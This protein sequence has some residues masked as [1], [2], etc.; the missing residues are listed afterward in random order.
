M[1]SSLPALHVV[2]DD[3]VIRTLVC[4][5][6]ERAGFRSEGFSSPAGFL[7]A[8][9]LEPPDLIVLDLA[10]GDTGGFAVLEALSRR[11][12][13]APLIV[14]AGLDDRLLGSAVR[15]GHGLG[16][17]MLEPLRKPAG[18]AEI[19]AAL[20][21]A[22]SKAL[23]I[24]VPDLEEALERGHL[25][26]YYQPKLRIADRSVVGA[27]ALV[28]WEH[29][30]RGTLGPGAFLAL[31]ESGTFITPLTF[32]MVER[33]AR[34]CAAW[35]EAG[36]PI[37]VA[38]NVSANCLGVPG[39]AE[40]VAEIVAAA[41]IEPGALT[42]E[43]TETAAMGDTATVAAALAWLR[44]RGFALAMDDFGTGYSSLAE[45]HRMPFSELKIDRSFVS[46]MLHDREAM[47]ITRAVVALSR[48]LG[49][50]T[51]AEGVETEP[52]LAA[53]AEMGCDVAQGFLIGRPMPAE[54]FS[55]WLGHGGVPPARL[56][57]AA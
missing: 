6:G 30:T 17:T 33:A 31:A 45:L 9:A 11:R 16:L 20:R 39:F 25:L 52:Q 23:P 14:S 27:E 38:V 10:I 56:V 12:C 1:S 35:R 41:G 55:T 3:P 34:D 47:V 8:A 2:D 21:D 49:L 22:A 51:V 18:P 32:M 44:I 19:L 28:R 36:H 53:L 7:E 29:P 5:V 4:K 37:G 54:A 48:A 46:A 40:H 13:M 42:I 43:I 57:A 15:I 26:P 24:R 50:R